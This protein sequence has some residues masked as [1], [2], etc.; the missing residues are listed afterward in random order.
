VLNIAKQRTPGLA[1]E[2]FSAEGTQEHDL[3]IAWY[4]LTDDGSAVEHHIARFVDLVGGGVRE[5]HLTLRHY[6]NG[7]PPDGAFG[8]LRRAV[9][10]D[11]VHQ[12]ELLSALDR[13]PQH[14][15][16]DKKKEK[17]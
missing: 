14:P 13:A 3:S 10:P 6:T 8:E 15:V 4:D 1:P 7:K 16:D 5:Y 9:E 11:T 17:K 2:T 12:V